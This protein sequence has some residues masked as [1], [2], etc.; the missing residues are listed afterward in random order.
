MNKRIIYSALLIITI[1]S[2]LCAC[3]KD[4]ATVYFATEAQ[5]RAVADSAHRQGG[6]PWATESSYLERYASG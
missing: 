3:K 5:Q 6:H 4:D 2:G 1:M